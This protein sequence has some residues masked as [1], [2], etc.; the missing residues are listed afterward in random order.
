MDYTK[1]F[2]ALLIGAAAGATLGVLFAPDRGDKTRDKLLS[3]AKSKGKE[4]EDYLDE[5]VSYAKRKADEGKDKVNK[6]SGEIQNKAHEV[7]SKIEDEAKNK[8]RQQFS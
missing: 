7:T 6:L 1:T 8:G 4:F 5:G 3:F 2:A